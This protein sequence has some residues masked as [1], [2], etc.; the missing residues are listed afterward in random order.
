MGSEDIKDSKKIESTFQILAQNHETDYKQLVYTL[1]SKEVSSNQ[2]NNVRNVLQVKKYF[3]GNNLYHGTTL[4]R[5]GIQ[6]Y[7]GT[8]LPY[9]YL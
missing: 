8:A 5:Y 7:I 3:F 1:R 6:L 4:K 9:R 2:Q